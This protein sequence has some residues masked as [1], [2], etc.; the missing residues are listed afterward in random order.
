MRWL[1]GCLFLVVATNVFAQV[2]APTHESSAE[3]R[4]VRVQ[5]GYICGW[6]GG[7]GYRSDLTTV[8]RSFIVRE[9][10]DAEDPKKF[11]RRKERRTISKR[12]WETLV[13]SIDAKALRAVPQ[14][15]ICRPCIDQPDSWVE[16]AYSDGSKVSVHYDWYPGKAPASVKALKFPILPIVFYE[17]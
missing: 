12:E 3:V 9:M 6:C 13:R 16:I 17:F 1:A 4:V 8:E 2:A 15:G 7:A 14:D 5:M 10:A 11:P